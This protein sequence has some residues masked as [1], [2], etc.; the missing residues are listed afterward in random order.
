MKLTP[1]LIVTCYTEYGK[2]HVLCCEVVTTQ[3]NQWH[4]MDEMP[5][6]GKGWI[7][8]KRQVGKLWRVGEKIGDLGKK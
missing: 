2:T 7:E 1:T 3:G 8:R 6:A 4:Q 5:E